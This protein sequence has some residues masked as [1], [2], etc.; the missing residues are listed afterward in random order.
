[1]RNHYEPALPRASETPRTGPVISTKDVLQTFGVYV[2]ESMHETLKSVAKGQGKK[3]SVLIRELVERGYDRFE[4]ALEQRSGRKILDVYEQKVAAYSGE[5]SQWMARLDRTLSLEIKLTA[6]EYG[7]SASQIVGGF[8]AEE[9][10]YCL[11]TQAV[12][13]C[14][15]V[16]VEQAQAA[17]AGFVGPKASELAIALGLPGKRKLVNELVWGI[18]RA[19]SVLLDRAAE[20]FK[21]SQ[22]AIAQAV[23]LNFRQLPAPSFKAP[24]GQPK[25][26]T[27][28]VSWEEA[29][30][31]LNLPDDEEAE[32]LA[33]GD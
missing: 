7:R 32:L 25:I 20:F 3:F 14:T 29:V 18:V 10:S 12:T 26:L 21:V 9:L 4:E 11:Q 5:N 15:A 19:P 33:L 17:M 13:L 2:P 16:E 22:Q 6:K 23:S 24:N 1:M 31:S 27:E 8:L 30:R 28:P